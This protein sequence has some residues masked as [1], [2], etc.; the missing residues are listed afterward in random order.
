MTALHK[1]AGLLAT[2]KQL[3]IPGVFDGLSATLAA[4]SG[5]ECIYLSGFSVSG[6]LLG[7]PDIGLVT[8]TEMA[9]K[10]RQVVAAA[11]VPVIA[12]GDN[13]HGG[14][15]NVER[16]VQLYEQ[17][18]VSCIQLEDQVTPKRCG[19]MEAKQVVSAAD[20][21]AK[22]R[23]AADCR[24]STE[25][26][27]MAR[28]D[29]LATDGMDEAL[30]RAEAYLNAGAD[31]LFVEAPRSIDDLERIAGQFKGQHLVAN[32]VED[33]KTPYLSPMELEAL[34]FNLVLY[35]VSALLAA[36]NALQDCYRE[37]KRGFSSTGSKHRVTFSE[38]N[39][40]VG[41]PDTLERG[42]HYR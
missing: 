24:S 9:E 16:L 8:A 5:F 33:G 18:G 19:H 27:V 12:D 1:L 20:A 30:R 4:Q 25:F 35:P 21:A 28:T 2:G 17:A 29:A 36:A 13:G 40:L 31:I 42:K 6:T 10:A 11:K 23:M 26:L 41:L 39:E 7:S 32:L 34:G 37:M 15:M 22:I 14:P 38:F 3:V